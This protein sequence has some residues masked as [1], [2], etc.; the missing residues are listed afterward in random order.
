M[1]VR[2][3]LL[4]AMMSILGLMRR[5]KG[6]ERTSLDQFIESFCTLSTNHHV[7]LWGESAVPQILAFFWFR[8]KFDGTMGTDMLLRILIESIS[9][10]NHPRSARGL[11]S[12]Y[13]SAEEVLPHLMG[14]AT[15]PITEKFCGQSFSLLGLVHMFARRLWMQQMRFLWPNISRIASTYQELDEPW[16][17]FRWHNTDATQVDVLPKHTKTWSELLAESE[18]HQG[19]TVPETIKDHPILFLLF[20]CV[21][22]HRMSADRIRWLDHKLSKFN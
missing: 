17:V 2:I 6:L 18:E 1:D 16:K 12:P 13:Y 10:Q 8:R 5:N 22:P 14:L 4:I 21:Y 15:E 20:L 11:F 3:T 9:I 19:I 7:F